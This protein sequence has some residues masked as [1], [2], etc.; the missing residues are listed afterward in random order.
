MQ[1]SNSE[2]L[3]NLEDAVYQQCRIAGLDVVW[4]IGNEEVFNEG[5]DFEVRSGD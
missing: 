1:K 2:Q 3:C 4:S 5:V